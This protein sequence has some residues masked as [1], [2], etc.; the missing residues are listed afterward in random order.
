MRLKRNRKG[1]ALVILSESKKFL[2]KL[3]GLADEACRKVLLF[4][5]FSQRV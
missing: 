5:I 3:S 4:V 1:S 2:V